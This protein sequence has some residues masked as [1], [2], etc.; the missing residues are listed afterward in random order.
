MET[1]LNAHFISISRLFSSGENRF[2][3]Q[4][5]RQVMSNYLIKSFHAFP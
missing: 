1:I 5:C 2:P 4:L 3:G